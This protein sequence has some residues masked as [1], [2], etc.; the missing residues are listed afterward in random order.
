MVDRR[1]AVLELFADMDFINFKRQGTSQ[2]NKMEGKGS[3]K[4]QRQ[5]FMLKGQFNEL[6]HFTF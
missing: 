4:L 1:F 5:E 3:E 6:K 2:L